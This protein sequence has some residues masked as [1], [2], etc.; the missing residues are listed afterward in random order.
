MNRKILVTILLFS[1][2]IAYAFAFLLSQ[3]S[4]T[5]ANLALPLIIANILMVA[6]VA[7]W[8]KLSKKN[9]LIIEPMNERTMRS[10]FIVASALVLIA[11]VSSVSLVQAGVAGSLLNDPAYIYG[12]VQVYIT[13]DKQGYCFLLS[14]NS[15]TYFKNQ[16]QRTTDA[17]V[18]YIGIGGSGAISTFLANW[19]FSYAKLPAKYNPLGAIIAGVATGLSIMQIKSENAMIQQDYSPTQG[20]ALYFTHQNVQICNWYGYRWDVLYNG[21]EFVSYACER[22]SSLYGTGHWATYYGCETIWT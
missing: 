10:I 2:T 6:I 4:T 3:M 1:P 16:A 5:V 15:A 11:M 22:M 12:D 19:I 13:P 7:L 18:G 21:D 14:P 20:I 17:A 8:K 9:R